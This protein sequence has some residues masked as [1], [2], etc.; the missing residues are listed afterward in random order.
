LKSTKMLKFCFVAV[1]VVIMAGNVFAGGLNLAGVGAKALGMAGAFRAVADDWSAMYWNPAGLAGQAT[2]IHLEA[3]VL[4]PVTWVTPNGPSLNDQYDGY[5]LYRNGVEQTSVA[6]QY[7]AGAFAFVYQVNEKFTAGLSV[8]APAALGAEWDD[9]FIAPFHGY[10]EDPAYP[11]KDWYSDLK[12]IDIHP[13][14]GYQVA[15]KV[16]V[17]VGFSIRHSSIT[18]QNP[19][20]QIYPGSVSPA[21]HVFIDGILEG[22]GWGYGF[23]VGVLVDITEKL[24]AGIVYAGEIVITHDGTVEQTLYLPG[25]AGGGT[26]HAIPDAEADLPLPAEFGFGLAYDVNEKLTVA[27]DVHWTNWETLETIDIL[28]DG[29]GLLVDPTTGDPIPADDV[30]K[31]MYW[32]NTLRYNVGM[33]YVASE[34]L[35]LR[36]G[37]Y[38]DPTPIPDKTLVATITDVADKS[39]ISIGFGYDLSENFNLEGYWEH[40][41]SGEKTAAAS[42]NTGDGIY[43]NVPGDWKMQVDTF[44]FQLNYRF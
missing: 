27:A 6:A 37:Y 38:F 11:D 1:L 15:E 4:F 42:D 8:Y 43:D 19:Q 40:L 32:E 10:R 31:E 3:K 16:A 39:N 12:V 36:L 35:D 5:Y 18:L 29:D 26:R 28:L 13:T 34:K 33:N 21:N 23:N 20:V 14:F 7:P 44:G 25:L 9:L 17:G 24:H 41:V 22:S 30:V 2:G